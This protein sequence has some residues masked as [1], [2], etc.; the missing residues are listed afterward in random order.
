MIFTAIVMTF[1]LTGCA[2]KHYPLATNVTLAESTL[3]DCKA[4][5]LELA[6]TRSVQQ[7]IESIGEF[8]RRTVL[9]FLGDFGIGNGMSK[10]A[11]RKSVANRL[12]QLETLQT[13]KC[14]IN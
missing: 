10:S 7:E 13:T 9:G 8:D 11:A 3:M 1:T 14:D 5:N 4:I 2:T 6:K 12:K